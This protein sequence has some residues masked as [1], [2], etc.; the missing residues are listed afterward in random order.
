[1]FRMLDRQSRE[2]YDFDYA[3][4]QLPLAAGAGALSA[5][6]PNLI[7]VQ[8]AAHSGYSAASQSGT[9]IRHPNP[10]LGPNGSSCY[11]RHR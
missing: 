4:V 8:V 7:G 11:R 2:L 1:S 6:P 9:P 5:Q 3:S 10:A